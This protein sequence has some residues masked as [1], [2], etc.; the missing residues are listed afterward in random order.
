MERAGVLGMGG[1]QAMHAARPAEVLPRAIMFVAVVC[2]LERHAR[3]RRGKRRF[4]VGIGPYPVLLLWEE[5]ARTNL[6]ISWTCISS[7]AVPGAN[8]G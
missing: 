7:R 3:F 2:L 4:E 5:D 1:R 6:S 8:R